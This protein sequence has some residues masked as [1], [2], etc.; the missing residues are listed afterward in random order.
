MIV[1]QNILVH[2]LKEYLIDQNKSSNILV[3]M[4]RQQS[5]TYIDPTGQRVDLAIF[6]TEAI[7]ANLLTK[8]LFL[9]ESTIAHF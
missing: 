9:N 3:E 2:Q 8:I 1:M 7:L 4:E 5:P 6:E